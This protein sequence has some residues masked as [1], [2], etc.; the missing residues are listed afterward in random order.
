MFLERGVT[1]VEG[2][3]TAEEVQQARAGLQQTL[4]DLG[5]SSPAGLRRLSSTNGAGGILDLFYYPWKLSLNEHPAVVDTVQTLW[6]HSYAA[7]HPH[8]SHPYG[9]FNHAHGYMYIDRVCYRL[10]ESVNVTTGTKKHSLQRCLA[11]HLDCCPHDLYGTSPQTNVRKWRPIQAFIA[12]TDTLNEQEG[13]FE[14]C[15]GL[16][17]EFN[18]WVSRR[19]PSS[20][21]G[22]SGTSPPIHLQ[23]N[24]R[25]QLIVCKHMP[26]A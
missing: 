19:P 8:F 6:R 12:L 14:A 4:D 21:P 7:G 20:S 26:P 1:V 15:P 5:A 17:K 13:G 23:C 16:H 22:S 9:E 10:P 2:V 24:H 25:R 18:E 3:L 11:P